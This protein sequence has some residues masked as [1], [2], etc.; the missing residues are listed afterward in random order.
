M[1]CT[2]VVPC[3][4]VGPEAE[5][6]ERF[7]FDADKPGE[8][9]RACYAAEAAGQRAALGSLATDGERSE[10]R[11][12]TRSLSCVLWGEG[13]VLDGDQRVDLLKIDVEG[14]ELQALQGIEARHWDRVAQVALEVHDVDGR[15]GAVEAL[16][17][18]R[19]YRVRT[20]AQRSQLSGD[21]YLAVV[22]AALRLFYVFARRE[23]ALARAA[24]SAGEGPEAGG[25]RKRMRAGPSPQ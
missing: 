4:L 1:F 7:I 11:V 10:F 2:Q 12:R 9:H 24:A 16:L 8:T 23:P 20:A 13:G 25:A 17:E 19:G 3:G 6:E 18:A 5:L 22:P 15:L 14:D 21:G